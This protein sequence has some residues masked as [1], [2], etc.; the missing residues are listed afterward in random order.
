MKKLI[1]VLIL[2][3]LFSSCLPSGLKYSAES[4]ANYWNTD[5][6]DISDSG[7]ANN[8]TIVL[9][10][11]EIEGLKASYPLKS[12]ADISSVKFLENLAE[13]DQEGYNYVKISI[14]SNNKTFEKKYQLT[15]IMLAQKFAKLSQS[16]FMQ[17]NKNDYSAVDNL[18]DNEKFPEIEKNKIKT[19]FHQIDS[20]EGKCIAISFVSFDLKSVDADNK[21]VIVVH[22]DVAYKN[23][24]ADYMTVFRISDNKII[25]FALNDNLRK[26]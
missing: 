21:P 23:S 12:I 22:T 8:K 4:V 24:F 14:N 2:F 15:E 25:H 11:G 7:E 17:I 9:N 5:D 26:Q 3:V 6:F 19:M 16:I 1:G 10:I 18:F 20:V 13:S